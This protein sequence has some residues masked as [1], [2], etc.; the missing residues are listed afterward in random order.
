MRA[1]P[2][3]PEV[4]EMTDDT[5]GREKKKSKVTINN[6]A[7]IFS[8]NEDLGNS[9]ASDLSYQSSLYEQP[10]SN[11]RHSSGSG[12]SFPQP[13]AEMIPNGFI[14]DYYVERTGYAAGTT[15]F[16]QGPQ[17]FP[18]VHFVEVESP[19]HSGLEPIAEESQLHHSDILVDPDHP[20]RVQMETVL[21][22]LQ[23][24][25]PGGSVAGSSSAHNSG[26]L[27]TIPEEDREAGDGEEESVR[28]SPPSTASRPAGAT[29]TTAAAQ[30]T[31]SRTSLEGTRIPR[32]T[33]KKIEKGKVAYPLFKNDE[34]GNLENYLDDRRGSY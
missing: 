34:T 9:K 25:N 12:A 30:P 8:S 6:N 13:P 3:A 22:E 31:P 26:G 20:E 17:E 5:V 15:G 23:A 2:F 7:T 16:L 10:I 24:R 18:E 19:R 33:L 28:S 32:A 29:A 4:Q 1:Q 14:A 21:L 27:A 11:G